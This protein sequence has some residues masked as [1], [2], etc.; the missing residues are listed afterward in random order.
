MTDKD[1][2]ISNLELSTFLERILSI[3]L[4][5]VNL[6]LTPWEFQTSRQ[7]FNLLK[8]Q[9]NSLS[10]PNLSK[11]IKD[12]EKSYTDNLISTIFSKTRSEFIN[13]CKSTVDV[14]LKSLDSN[15]VSNLEVLKNL[16]IDLHTCIAIKEKFNDFWNSLWNLNLD[17]SN[18]LLISK[19]LYELSQAVMNY[20]IL[21]G[22][23]LFSLPLE[24][25]EARYQRK[26]LNK[27]RFDA[28]SNDDPEIICDARI[29]ANNL[30]QKA[31]S[32]IGKFVE[33]AVV[34]FTIELH[35]LIDCRVVYTGNSS[36]E[37][38]FK[39]LVD[40]IDKVVEPLYPDKKGIFY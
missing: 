10:I 31:G 30:K 26:R 12:L 13:N 21:Y 24:S 23:K 4:E 36:L 34:G 39:A 22:E 20:Y 15:L 38:V 28:V 35:A 16:G 2:S 5:S 40:G 29:A 14:Q 19:V 18:I 25:D 7:I 8:T 1:Y 27:N 33:Y 17:S 3:Y 11:T 32:F 9:G 6:I 37:N